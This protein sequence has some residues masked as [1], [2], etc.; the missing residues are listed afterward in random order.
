MSPTDLTSMGSP[1]G[2]PVPWHSMAPQLRPSCHTLAMHAFCCSTDGLVMGDTLRPSEFW[3]MPARSACGSTCEAPMAIMGLN[4][5]AATPSPRPYPL[6]SL[7]KGLQRSPDVTRSQLTQATNSSDKCR[8]MLVF[9]HLANCSTRCAICVLD[10]VLPFVLETV[11]K[12]QVSQKSSVTSAFSQSHAKS[13]R[14]FTM[15]HQVL[16]GLYIIESATRV[17]SSVL[18]CCTGAPACL[19]SRTESFEPSFWTNVYL[20]KNFSACLM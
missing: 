19:K 15:F 4:A 9:S 16:K 11:L 6:A 2:V 5:T 12:N 14:L 20:P 7:W 18:Q 1:V 10:F 3:K 13:G 17:S 8:K